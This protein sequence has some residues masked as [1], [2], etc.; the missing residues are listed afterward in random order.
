MVAGREFTLSLCSAPS[1]TTRCKK[2]NLG[3][4][5]VDAGNVVEKKRSAQKLRAFAMPGIGAHQTGSG[6]SIFGA[7]T[8][9][10]SHGRH[11]RAEFDPQLDLPSGILSVRL[12]GHLSFAAASKC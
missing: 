12:D 8:C 6:R 11:L 4:P 9:L 1:G 3:T 5:V 10:Q 2:S 7:N